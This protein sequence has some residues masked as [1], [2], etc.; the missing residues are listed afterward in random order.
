MISWQDYRRHDVWNI[1][2]VYIWRKEKNCEKYEKHS[3][4]KYKKLNE[5]S[6]SQILSKIH[7]KTAMA[8]DKKSIILL[9]WIKIT[10]NARAIGLASNT[11]KNIDRQ[12]LL[13]NF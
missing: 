4:T 9:K 12:I 1:I 7:P 3:P 11:Y 2:Y 8:E 5:F 6:A 13:A 10:Q